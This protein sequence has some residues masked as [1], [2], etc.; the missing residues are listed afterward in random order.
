MSQDTIHAPE[1]SGADYAHAL[2]QMPSGNICFERGLE[3]QL[4]RLAVQEV[5]SSGQMSSR[6]DK[7]FSLQALLCWVLFAGIEMQRNHSMAGGRAS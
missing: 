6:E 4:L 7:V 1:F 3:L 2:L 5:V